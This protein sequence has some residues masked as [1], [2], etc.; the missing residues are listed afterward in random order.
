VPRHARKQVNQVNRDSKL[1]L[2]RVETWRG[3]SRPLIHLIHLLPLLRARQGSET[4][5]D[6]YS[7]L[8]HLTLFRARARRLLKRLMTVMEVARKH[9]C[10]WC[11]GSQL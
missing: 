11:A 7:S 4:G 8:E 6:V 10:W 9:S 1:R 5:D 3:F 2:Y